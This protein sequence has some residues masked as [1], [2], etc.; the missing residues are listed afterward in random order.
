VDA[1]ALEAHENAV[2]HR[3]PLRVFR[4]AVGA[5]L[6]A[7]SADVSSWGK[8][9]GIGAGSATGRQGKSSRG[10][11]HTREVETRERFKKISLRS[12]KKH[13]CLKLAGAGLEGRRLRTPLSRSCCSS[14]R[15]AAASGDAMGWDRTSEATLQ[16]AGGGVMRGFSNDG[17]GKI[18]P[19]LALVARRDV[20]LN[21]VR[22]PERRRVGTVRSI[23]DLIET[24]T[25]L[26]DNRRIRIRSYG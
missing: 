10:P 11:Q 12:D 13:A 6:E 22:S 8:V 25:V 7:G 18:F 4:F 14:R 15:V 2:R 24:C 3:C 20:G 17:T 26:V 1:R 9:R 23:R 21:R 19:R 5:Y 16:G